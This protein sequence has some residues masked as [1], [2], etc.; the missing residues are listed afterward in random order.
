M[1]NTEQTTGVVKRLRRYHAADRQESLM[2]TMRRWIE[3][4]LKPRTNEGNP[5]VNPILV[6]LAVIVLLAG[7]TFLVFSFIQ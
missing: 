5:R 6:L 4:P 2:E 3:D 1:S 7:G